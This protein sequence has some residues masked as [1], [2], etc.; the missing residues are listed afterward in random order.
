MVPSVTPDLKTTNPSMSCWLQ[1]LVLLLKRLKNAVG[2]IYTPDRA[3]RTWNF[4][5]VSPPSL[6]IAKQLIRS[7]GQD[8]ECEDKEM[9]ESREELPASMRE[10]RN[11]CFFDPNMEWMTCTNKR[12]YIYKWVPV[13]TMSRVQC[14][15][16]SRFQ[17]KSSFRDR[18]T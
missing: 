11:F 15:F 14:S 5:Q 9:F 1:E 6:S 2:L 18:S 10:V 3:N 8:S 13:Q 16:W 12:T 4:S 17:S 7:R